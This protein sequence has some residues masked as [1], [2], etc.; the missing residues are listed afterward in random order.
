MEAVVINAA[1]EQLVLLDTGVLSQKTI[2]EYYLRSFLTIT[3]N[4]KVHGA[5]ASAS[6]LRLTATTAAPAAL[7]ARTDSFVLSGNGRSSIHVHHTLI[8]RFLT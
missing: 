2:T 6:T 4:V 3:V 8:S 7:Y 5:M 1:L